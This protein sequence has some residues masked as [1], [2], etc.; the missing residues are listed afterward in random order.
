MEDIVNDSLPKIKDAIIEGVK[1][2]N[3]KINKKLNH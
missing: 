1:A 2:E 3:L